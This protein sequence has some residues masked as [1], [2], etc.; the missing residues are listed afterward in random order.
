MT[1]IQ[2]VPCKYLYSI[3]YS[4]HLL[5]NHK[6]KKTFAWATKIVLNKKNSKDDYSVSLLTIVNFC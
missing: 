3:Y 6:L 1:Y 4:K 2:N 5:C